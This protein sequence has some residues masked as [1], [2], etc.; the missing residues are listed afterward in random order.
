MSQEEN[1]TVFLIMP[2]TA[3]ALLVEDRRTRRKRANR[4]R[5]KILSQE[6]WSP[7]KCIKPT[8]YQVSMEIPRMGKMTRS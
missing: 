2:T 1:K 8:W 3:S 6:S 7:P 5:E 4:E